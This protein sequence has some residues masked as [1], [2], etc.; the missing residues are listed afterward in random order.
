M[1]IVPC[2]QS[3]SNRTLTIILRKLFLFLF[4]KAKFD[5]RSLMISLPFSPS[6][7]QTHFFLSLPLSFL[8]SRSLY[9]RASFV[10]RKLTL[11][12]LPG[13][14]WV[15]IRK[16]PCLVMLLH[17]HHLI[18][19]LVL[20]TNRFIVNQAKLLWRDKNDFRDGSCKSAVP[21]E[22]VIKFFGKFFRM[23][24]S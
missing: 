4:C 24:A 15:V 5:L 6:P 16:R 3:D 18:C 12:N 1:Y 21:L 13:S 22:L 11:L 23:K 8:F 2:M 19:P 20:I 17:S 7:S 14:D 10:F 9:S